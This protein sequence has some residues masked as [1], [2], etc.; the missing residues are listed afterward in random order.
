MDMGYPPSGVSRLRRSRAS[1]IAGA[2]RAGR[3][4]A[5]AGS[6]CGYFSPPSGHRQATS[7]SAGS[8]PACRTAARTAAPALP[9]RRPR[10]GPGPGRRLPP[11]PRPGAGPPRPSGGARRSGSGA[12]TRTRPVCTAVRPELRRGRRSPPR[13]RPPQR[14]PGRGAG[15]AWR[16]RPGSPGGDRH[17]DG[18]EPA[19]GR[20]RGQFDGGPRLV[21]PGVGGAR[22]L[23]RPDRVRVPGEEV[24]DGRQPG[25]Q[26]GGAGRGADGQDLG[27]VGHHAV[28]AGTRR[29]LLHHQRAGVAPGAAEPGQGDPQ[30]AGSRFHHPAPRTEAA[31]LLQ[32]VQQGR[33]G[34]GLHRPEGVLRLQLEPE[35]HR[36]AGQ[37]HPHGAHRGAPDGRGL[38]QRR[39]PRRVAGHGAPFPGVAD[40]AAGTSEGGRTRAPHSR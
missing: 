19:P 8:A 5:W 23:V 10:R 17:A 7:R 35:P 21:H 30:V 9:P 24:A 38:G 12:R 1:A 13:R 27:A 3:L 4:P 15:S 14:W 18:V 6:I 39:G 37:R 16:H 32:A 2:A 26:R 33:R 22:V 28:H 34:A 36:P 40:A 29:G 20:G 31:G 11:R 25:V